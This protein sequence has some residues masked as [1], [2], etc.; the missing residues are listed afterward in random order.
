LDEESWHARR[1]LF[2]NRPIRDK[3]KMVKPIRS[4]FRKDGGLAQPGREVNL[5]YW[6]P[7]ILILS[8][9]QPSPK[10]AVDF[11]FPSVTRTPHYDMFR[12]E[13]YF[14]RPKGLILFSLV[15]V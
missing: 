8:N 7:N 5:S 11:Y 14:S 6:K 2:K 12:D 15:Q 4:N 10:L 13:L 9:S 1:K 3:K